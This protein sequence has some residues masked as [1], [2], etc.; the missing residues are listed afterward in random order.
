L[1]RG[2]RSPALADTSAPTVGARCA[3]KR[4]TSRAPSLPRPGDKTHPGSVMR[5]YSGLAAIER[6]DALNRR[7]IVRARERSPRRGRGRPGPSTLDR[8]MGEGG[9]PDCSVV[10]ATVTGTTVAIIA[11]SVVDLSHRA[12]VRAR[13]TAPGPLGGPPPTAPPASHCSAGRASTPRHVRTCARGRRGRGTPLAGFISPPFDSWRDR[14][15]GRHVRRHVRDP[16]PDSPCR[17][18][19]GRGKRRPQPD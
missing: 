8:L 17:D 7:S 13:K 18:M 16:L 15:R 4:R 19:S 12:R 2:H 3:R 10:W 11:S 6:P 14:Y 1:R 9:P 5:R